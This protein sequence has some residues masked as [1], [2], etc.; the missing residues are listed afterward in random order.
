MARLRRCAI[1]AAL[2]LAAL[3]AFAAEPSLGRLTYVERKVEQGASG[4]WREA[5]EAGMLK[6]G[7][8]FRTAPDA[9]LR[10]DFS[11]MSM[12]VSA[13]SVVRFPEG[14]FLEAVLDRGRVALVAEHREI[15]KLRTEDAEVRGQGRVVVRRLE[16]GTVVSSLAGDFSVEGAAT[17]VAV[18]AGTGTIIH[19]GAAPILPVALPPVPEGLVPGSDPVFV[20][21]DQPVHLRWN[22]NAATYHVEVFA[23]GSDTVLMERDVAASEVELTVPWTGAFRWRVAGRDAHGLE[24]QPSFYGL[25]CVDN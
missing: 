14:H 6:V 3:A 5:Q 12:T 1:F 8:Q 16:H 9:V 24:G 22:G 19:A 23:V 13:A 18:P 21:P 25:F 2:G 4:A 15:L 7:E 17:V 11:W 10:V 20:T